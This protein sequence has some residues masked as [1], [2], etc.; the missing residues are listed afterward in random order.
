MDTLLANN[1]CIAETKSAKKRR[2]KKE[3]QKTEKLPFT[4]EELEAFKSKYP[5]SVQKV[6][7]DFGKFS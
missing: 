6:V 1:V 3:K 5:A 7:Q 4:D 2:K